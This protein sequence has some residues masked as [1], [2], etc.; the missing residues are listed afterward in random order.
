MNKK[1]IQISSPSTDNREWKETKKSFHNGW[2]TQG[3]KVYEFEKLFKNKFSYKYALAVSSC[4]AGLHLALLALGIGKGDEVILPSFTWVSSANVVEQVGAKIVLV[5]IQ[6]DNFNISLSEILKKINK[7]T[8]AIIVTHLFGN[9]FDVNQLKKKIT[10][11]IKIIEDCACAVGA[12]H[13]DIFAGNLGDIGVFSFHPRK[14]ITT[15]EGGMIVTKNKKIYETLN[16]YRNHGASI[17]EEQKNKSNKP[18]LMPDFIVPGLNYR[19]TDIQGAVGKVQLLKF[20]DLLINRIKWSNYYKEKI[21]NI[22]WLSVPREI[23]NSQNSLQAFVLLVNKDKIHI[24]RN[25]IMEIL[26]LNSIASRPGTHAIHMLNY[27]KRKYQYTK[28]QYINSRI[29]SE[30]SLA[31]PLHKSITKSQYDYIIKIIYLIDKK[32]KK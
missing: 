10:K 19:M 14:I 29:A 21:N 12:S 9:V 15:G 11:K 24:T 8:R 25:K 17:S 26:E 23:S 3:P 4:T 13:K 16:S 32:Y 18:Y 30:N 27:Y 7:K 5:D 22:D 2:I 31:L 1:Y 6:K 20:D 28:N